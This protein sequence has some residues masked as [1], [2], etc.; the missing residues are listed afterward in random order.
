MYDT[1]LDK[2]LQTGV[3]G[4][5]LILLGGLSVVPGDQAGIF[6]LGTGIILLGLNLM[7]Y[8]NKYPV[9]GFSTTFGAVAL[10]LGG[11]A[12]LRLILGWEFRYELSF[13]PILLI[14]IG[15]YLLIPPPRQKEGG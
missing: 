15:L 6:V 7:R 3:W 11:L 14:A 13:F 1:K 9:N 4:I 12:S 2:R 5:I 10:M 8:I